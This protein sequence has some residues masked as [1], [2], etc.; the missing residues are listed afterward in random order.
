MPLVS[1]GLSPRRHL[2]HPAANAAGSPGQRSEEGKDIQPMPPATIA[3]ALSRVLRYQAQR[4]FCRFQ[5]WRCAMRRFSLKCWVGALLLAGGLVQAQP[6]AANDWHPPAS[7][8]GGA[9]PEGILQAYQKAAPPQFQLNR[10]RPV[11]VQQ[12][13]AP[14]RAPVNVLPAPHEVTPQSTARRAEAQPAQRAPSAV[15]EARR[16]AA[17][18]IIQVKMTEPGQ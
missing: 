11:P 9:S 6:K 13:P 15:E 18:E 8:W 1:N 12:T 7:I 3:P 16:L 2:G 14:R 4:S 5:R 17:Q 10:L